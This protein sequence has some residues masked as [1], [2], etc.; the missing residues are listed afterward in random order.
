MSIREDPTFLVDQPPPSPKQSTVSSSEPSE[1]LPY[2]VQL[3]PQASFV[4]ED[5][6]SLKERDKS[7]ERVKNPS[8]RY[9][10]TRKGSS[11]Q[12]DSPA[13]KK[14]DHIWERVKDAPISKHDL[15]QPMYI[16]RKFMKRQPGIK[17]SEKEW[18]RLKLG[19][20]SSYFYHNVV[21][22]FGRSVRLESMLEF[23][24]DETVR[25]PCLSTAEG[26][27]LIN[28]ILNIPLRGNHSKLLNH[29]R[30][31]VTRLLRQR[32]D[33][34]QL[35][36]SA[37]LRRQWNISLLVSTRKILRSRDAMRQCE[38]GVSI[39]DHY[40]IKHLMYCRDMPSDAANH[41]AE[42]I[43]TDH[44]ADQRNKNKKIGYLADVLDGVPPA[45]LESLIPTV[46][47]ALL[48]QSTSDAELVSTLVEGGIA[49][50]LTVLQ[51]MKVEPDS[52]FA[53][54]YVPFLAIDVLTSAGHLHPAFA[55][56]L[57]KLESK[58]IAEL[59]LNWLCGYAYRN[60]AEEARR[61]IERFAL[62]FK[63]ALDNEA[64]S[65]LP[66]AELLA[67]LFFRTSDFLVPIREVFELT[68][69]F[70]YQ[71]KHPDTIVSLLRRY[72]EKGGTKILDQAFLHKFM[73]RVLEERRSFALSLCQS[74]STFASFFDPGIPLAP[75]LEAL[76]TRRREQKYKIQHMVYRSELGQRLPASLL[77]QPLDNLL[78]TYPGLVHQVAYQYSLD[79]GHSNREI[80]RN[81]RKLWHY[82]S[83]HKLPLSPLFSAAMVR[84][85]LT[86]PLSEAQWVGMERVRWI[87]DIVALCEG[88]AAARR[89]YMTSVLWKKDL[90]YR[91]DE[92]W[93]Q[94][95]GE[96]PAH[97]RTMKRLKLLN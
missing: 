23:L 37:K 59:I 89:V 13:V 82:I 27:A 4:Q 36:E 87:C 46:T 71:Y 80:Q 55:A 66:L 41:I 49:R 50:W 57:Q 40:I 91:A 11:T 42:L 20:D 88:P 60:N 28:S 73:A 79:R 54:K 86:R 39:G 19:R 22:T 3:P 18:D 48:K 83:V 92:R 14:R 69:E 94:I 29:Y 35:D 17:N 33:S 77:D 9:H 62:K 16:F 93:R 97:L 30:S 32:I 65:K 5:S 44:K 81:V 15:P 53:P 1:S 64:N 25:P 38:S 31:V 56:Y 34:S 84:L 2:S 7:Q 21:E 70:L 74:L 90:L 12:E 85:F 8:I 47:S 76:E 72:E 63:S 95:G 10:G 24:L 45:I 58:A 43:M 61:P 26:T 96:G 78:K 75:V 68:I 52:I 6:Q 67:E 51:L